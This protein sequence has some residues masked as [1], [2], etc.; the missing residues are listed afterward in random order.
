MSRPKPP[1]VRLAEMTPGQSGDFFALLAERTRGARRDGK[2]FFTCRFRDAGRVAAAMI[3]ADGDW[4]EDCEQRWQEGHFYKLRGRYEEHPTYGPQIEI[5]NIR[6]TTDA[7]R[8]DDAVGAEF[9][10]R[11]VRL[12]ESLLAIFASVTDSWL[13][14]NRTRAGVDGLLGRICLYMRIEDD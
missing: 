1:P 10:Q 3:W 11:R 6:E 12:A 8:A 7:D 9:L 14:E 4:F 2:P 13:V 5:Q